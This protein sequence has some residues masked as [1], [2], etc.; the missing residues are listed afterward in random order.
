MEETGAQDFDISPMCAYSVTGKTRVNEK[1]DEETFG[2]IFTSDIRTFEKELHSEM[3]KIII[4]NELPDNWTY[5]LI[6]PRIFEEAKNRN[7]L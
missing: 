5:P 4:T 7:V 6:Y 2:M 1:E 3:E